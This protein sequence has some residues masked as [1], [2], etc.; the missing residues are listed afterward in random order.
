MSGMPKVTAIKVSPLGSFDAV[1]IIATSITGCFVP[2]QI[3]KSEPTISTQ[4]VTSQTPA[5]KTTVHITEAAVTTTLM[6]S[7]FCDGTSVNILG[8]E[9]IY[10]KQIKDG[11]GNNVNFESFLSDGWKILGPVGD[12]DTYLQLQ[13]DAQSLIL[14][15]LAWHGTVTT[16]GVSVG[17]DE[18][19][20]PTTQVYVCKNSDVK[21][22]YNYAILFCL[23]RNF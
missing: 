13:L 20:L 4:P 7:Q 11:K 9:N 22:D 3:T 18:D 1:N 19:I 14:L 12:P 8:P 21:Y 2:Q 23:Q 10:I 6:P 15:N 17:L 16:L 5:P